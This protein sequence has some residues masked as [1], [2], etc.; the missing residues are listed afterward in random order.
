MPAN[1]HIS[2]FGLMSYLLA[3]N[4]RT[5]L[6]RTCLFF[7]QEQRNFVTRNSFQCFKFHAGIC[8]MFCFAYLNAYPVA[9]VSLLKFYYSSEYMANNI[10]KFSVK[11]PYSCMRR[12]IKYFHNFPFFLFPFAFPVNQSLSY[13]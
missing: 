12:I 11:K 1:S 6:K 10:D 8:N 3:R 2:C 7:K 4:S 13:L 5:M 9:Y